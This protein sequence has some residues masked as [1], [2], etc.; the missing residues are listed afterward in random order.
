VRHVTDSN[1]DVTI[2]AERRAD[3]LT[4]ARRSFEQI[5]GESGGS[6][7][8]AASAA[9]I[10]RGRGS[11]WTIELGTA[12]LVLTDPSANGAEPWRWEPP[13]F[14]VV[15]HASLTLEIPQNYYGY[16]GRSHSLWFGDPLEAG[17]F[18]W[19][20]V[21]FMGAPRLRVG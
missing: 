6:I 3:L 16:T 21:A 5:A 12:S 4:A 18:G 13:A 7:T 10:A 1:D 19:F 15:A 20:E 8:D 9:R 14:E 17:A 2:E 11:Q